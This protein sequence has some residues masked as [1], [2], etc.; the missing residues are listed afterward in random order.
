MIL[1]NLSGHQQYLS[2]MTKSDT[3]ITSQSIR[4]SSQTSSNAVNCNYGSTMIMSSITMPSSHHFNSIN[5][6]DTSTILTE[7]CSISSSPP[8]LLL[9][10]DVT[11]QRQNANINQRRVSLPLDLEQSI[12][13]QQQRIL[14]DN[15]IDDGSST[16]NNINNKCTSSTLFPFYSMSTCDRVHKCDNHYGT[17][18]NSGTVN[19]PSN[20]PQLVTTAPLLQVISSNGDETT[21][22][23]AYLNQ[24]VKDCLKEAFSQMSKKLN[25][26]MN[27]CGIGGDHDEKQQHKVY[28]SLFINNEPMINVMDATLTNP[29]GIEKRENIDY[30]SQTTPPRS[31]G[32]LNITIRH[33]IEQ[34]VSS[35]ID[36]LI[37]NEFFPNLTSLIAKQN[38]Q[39][40]QQQL[41]DKPPIITKE[42]VITTMF[43]D[44]PAIEQTVSGLNKIKIKIVK[45][46]G[47]LAKQNHNINNTL[48]RKIDFDD[49]TIATP[50]SIVTDNTKNV[51]T[52]ALTTAS[53]CPNTIISSA[54]SQ[55]QT[56]WPNFQ[57]KGDFEVAQTEVSQ[58]G[59]TRFHRRT[60]T[61]AEL[62]EFPLVVVIDFYYISGFVPRQEIPLPVYWP[63]MKSHTTSVLPEQKTQ[64]SLTVVEQPLKYEN[65]E[66]NTVNNQSTFAHSL[67]QSF[68]EKPKRS[69]EE[70]ESHKSPGHQYHYKYRRRR[71]TQLWDTICD[72]DYV[73]FPDESRSISYNL[74]Q[75]KSTGHLHRSVYQHINDTKPTSPQPTVPV[76]DVEFRVEPPTPALEQQQ[77]QSQLTLFKSVFEHEHGLDSHHDLT[78]FDS[79]IY[80]VSHNEA[81]FNSPI[82]THAHTL[83]PSHLYCFTLRNFFLP[84][85]RCRLRIN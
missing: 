74:Q 1:F 33:L 44:F 66:S 14:T 15:E 59:A 77:N 39:M 84:L 8:F 11:R 26:T 80:N 45:K 27:C 82:P 29:V 24:Y 43:I 56:S 79:N 31:P 78:N 28:E 75:S 16:N 76:A 85:T 70:V 4:P 48:N 19:Q 25:Q 49:S 83:A 68:T 35:M 81:I 37:Y 51:S 55:I 58:I 73:L 7:D 62:L 53:F 30:P 2:R 60:I 50:L 5:G 41:Y 12:K 57:S 10:R 6:T 47:L 34:S 61:Y 20:Q 13:K 63:L 64:Q 54:E 3:F 38:K 71:K 67:E 36:Q 69:V 32:P 18:K 17:L 42:N 23:D 40:Q 52:R 21:T 22:M 65:H 46:D 9:H 72:S